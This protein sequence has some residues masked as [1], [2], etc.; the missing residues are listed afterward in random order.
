MHV[1][2]NYFDK[3]E[4]LFECDDIEVQS[5][6]LLLI[7]GTDEDTRH[8][9]KVVNLSRI[10]SYETVKGHMPDGFQTPVAP[11]SSDPKKI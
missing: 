7:A 6:Y 8:K 5:G 11:K 10:N 2:L 9:V 1:K 4:E 3:K